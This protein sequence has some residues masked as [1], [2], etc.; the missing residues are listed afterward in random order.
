MV[1]Q[2]HAPLLHCTSVKSL[3]KMMGR[4]DLN[5]MSMHAYSTWQLALLLLLLYTKQ[6]YHCTWRD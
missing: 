5:S 1:P 3:A 2:R 6:L 4:S